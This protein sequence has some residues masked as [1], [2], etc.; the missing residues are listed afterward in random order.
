V[1]VCFY[2]HL[3][4]FL[5]LIMKYRSSLLHTCWCII[6]LCLNSN[7]GLNSLFGLC[8]KMKTFLLTPPSFSLFGP[9]PA[10]AHRQLR[11][12]AG[13]S[14]PAQPALVPARAPAT[15]ADGCPPPVIPL[16]AQPPAS[17]PSRGGGCQAYTPGTHTRKD[18]D[19]LLLEFP[20]NPTRTRSV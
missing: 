3:T 17:Q 13:L 18:E 14:S 20:C 1:C 16:A 15:A 12:P 5:N 10:A 19:G 9:A 11:G 6:L 7:S 2:R 4:I 8:L